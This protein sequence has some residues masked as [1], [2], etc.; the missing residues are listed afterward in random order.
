MV[1]RPSALVA[2]VL[3]LMAGSATGGC[4]ARTTWPRTLSTTALQARPVDR[5][6]WI[7]NYDTALVSIARIMERDLGLPAVPVDLHFY[8]DR[9]AF[10]AALE[11]GGYDGELATDA[12]ATM[13]AITGH[14]RVLLNDA[15]LRPLDW[16]FRVA[17]LAHELTHAVQYELAGGRRGTSEQWLREGFAEWVEV[18]VLTSLGFTTPDG[19]RRVAGERVRRTRQLPALTTMVTFPDWVRAGLRVGTEGIYAQ[20]LLAAGLLVERHGVPAVLA[21]FRSFR[22]SEDRLANFRQ[23]FGEDLAAF[24]A[25]FGAR[26]TES[27]R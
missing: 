13:A 24:E 4:A 26:L 14:R 9:E 16:P 3:A 18:E 11:A 5:G 21:Y 25:A 1:R 17:L 12:A 8:R 15:E 7:S 19:A 20:A 27:T 22:E 10:R 23:A 6:A 2:L